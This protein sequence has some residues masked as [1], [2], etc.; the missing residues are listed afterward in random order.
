MTFGSFLGKLGHW[1][2]F[3]RSFLILLLFF[4]LNISFLILL[5]PVKETLIENKIRYDWY[6]GCLNRVVSIKLKKIKRLEK[7]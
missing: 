2:D 1:V 3:F 6:D 5:F 4:S 7:I